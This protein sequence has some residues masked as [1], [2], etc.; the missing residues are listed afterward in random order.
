[1]SLNDSLMPSRCTSILLCF[2]VIILH[3]LRSGDTRRRFRTSSTLR[4]IN[5]W[6]YTQT[7]L[8]YRND[9]CIISLLHNDTTKKT[10]TLQNRFFS[11][12]FIAGF[13]FCATLYGTLVFISNC[14]H[15]KCKSIT[16]FAQTSIFQ[17]AFCAWGL[18]QLHEISWSVFDKGPQ[19]AFLYIRGIGET[20]T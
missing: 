10:A 16:F 5:N 2:C 4:H 14:I 3:Y 8:S 6:K 15:L 9:I 12:V 7:H 13:S 18:L 19:Y 11:P 1:M 17:D 20:H